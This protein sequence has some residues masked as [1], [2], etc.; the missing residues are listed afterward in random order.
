[1]IGVGAGKKGG[2]QSSIVVNTPYLHPLAD[3]D[4]TGSWLHW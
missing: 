4:D 2:M 3:A 1:L